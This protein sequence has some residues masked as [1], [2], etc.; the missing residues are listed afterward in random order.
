MNLVHRSEAPQPVRLT[1]DN[2]L[3]LAES[4]AFDHLPKK[5]ELLDGAITV[6]S[7][8]LSRHMFVK[9]EFAFRL[10]AKLR[11]MNVP[12]NV[13]VDGTLTA[14]PQNA[15]EPDIFLTSNPHGEGYAHVRDAPLVIE[16]AHT[17]VGHDLG[18]KKRIYAEAGVPEYW[19]VD[20]PAAAVHQFWSPR[21]QDY[22]AHRRV[23][24]G[25][26]IESVTIPGLTVPSDGL[27]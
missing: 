6:M 10:M 21:G 4:G 27:T 8:Q 23:P 18:P 20:I 3:L 11:E 19:V 15:P 1:V 5:V 12:Y 16:V 25:D 17:T 9:S 24:I 7:P 13:F 14:P 26:M 2:F 22:E